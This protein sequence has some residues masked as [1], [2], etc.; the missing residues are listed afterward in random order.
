MKEPEGK[1]AKQ[2]AGSVW[3]RGDTDSTQS[4]PQCSERSGEDAQQKAV[5]PTVVSAV[6]GEVASARSCK[7]T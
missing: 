5:Q 4:L 7:G 3:G 6:L 2:K 1:L